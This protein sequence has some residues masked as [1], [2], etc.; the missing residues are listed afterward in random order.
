LS[1]IYTDTLARAAEAQGSTQAV[2]S[3]LHVPENTLLRW[4]SGRAQMPLQ[5]FLR[6][7][8]LLSEYEKKGGGYPGAAAAESGDRLVFRM[9]K[10][11]GHCSRCDGTEFVPAV[12]TEAVKLTSA[13]GCCACGERVIH[14]N[15]IAQLAKDAVNQ[16]RAYT[17]A[18]TRRQVAI[19]EASAKRRAAGEAPN[20]PPQIVPPDES[21]D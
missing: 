12:P 4:M 1:D 11:M 17:A 9:G 18:R 20:P 5:A 8:E 7:V 21:G 13:L 15:L 16:S 10:L 2:A 6:L 3:L 19:R 14:G